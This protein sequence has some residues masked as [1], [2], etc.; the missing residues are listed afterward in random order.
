METATTWWLGSWAAADKPNSI[1]AAKERY[2][3]IVC[4]VLIPATSVGQVGNLP[5]IVK[6]AYRRIKMINLHWPPFCCNNYSFNLQER[7]DGDKRQE[8]QDF[9]GDDRN[10]RHG[11]EL[12]SP[13]SRSGKLNE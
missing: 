6:S 12:Q 4:C 10:R 2:I 11:E 9:G 5:P 1:T 3:N 13:G 8:T 7:A